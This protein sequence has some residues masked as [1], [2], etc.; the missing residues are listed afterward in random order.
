M[1]IGR[2]ALRL[3]SETGRLD[4]LGKLEQKLHKRYLFQLYQHLE[5]HPRA[6]PDFKGQ[7]S[8]S[9][10]ESEDAGDPGVSVLNVV[11]GV[12]IGLFERQVQIKLE[13]GRHSAHKEE[14]P[15]RI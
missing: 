9:L 13:M 6:A 5:L 8:F 12:L 15:N 4:D 1:Q 3:K 14:V 10:G 7:Q 2:E 11:D